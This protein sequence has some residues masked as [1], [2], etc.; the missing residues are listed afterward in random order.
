[1]PEPSLDHPAALLAYHDEL[2]F[3]A[4][5]PENA[6]AL[7]Q[8]RRE[9]KRVVAAARSIAEGAPARAR[10][11]L[12]GSGIAWSAIS[13]AFSYGIARWLAQSYP[14][15][16]EIDGAGMEARP[17]MEALRPA[18][19]RTEFALLDD[20]YDDLDAFF[21]AAKGNATQTNLA[22][23]VAQFERMPCGEQLRDRL[24]EALDLT[25]CV[26]PGGA[27]ISR[28][29]ARGLDAPAY[30]H[31]GVFIRRPDDVGRI[32][33]ER[34]PRPRA[35]SAAER[36]QLWDAARGV[37]AMLGRE[38]DPITLGYE[39]GVEYVELGRGVSIALFDMRAERRFALDTHL[40][41][42]LFKNAIPIG[43]G[44]GWPFLGTSKIG[45]NIFA[46]FRG[47]ESAL[48]FLQVLRVYH[49]RFGVERFLVEPYQF[50]ADNKEGLLSGAFWFYYRLGF[51]PVDR[52]VATLAEAEYER[53]AA[54]GG[55]RTSLGMMRRLVK[56]DIELNLGGKT[57]EARWPDPFDLSAAVTAWIA[58]EFA[59]DRAAADGA[60]VQRTQRALGV[61]G[62]GRWPEAE[63]RAFADLSMVVAQIPAL[64]RWPAAD[65]RA[66]IEVMRARGGRDERHYF[67][68]LQRHRRLREALAGIVA[69]HQNG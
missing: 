48:L 58:R 15:R 35:T 52:R 65:R 37:L 22:W 63:R 50:G 11:K 41:F 67:A 30:Y 20:E 23:L 33:R 39:D 21:T 18:M 6:A 10:A 45:V 2:L 28:T 36:R 24:Y 14:G 42:M 61:R 25:V 32:V 12:R 27:P 66:C 43:Y 40:G 4:A 17:V 49:Q 53:V 29:L 44:G 31:R 51:R 38:T 3:R 60:A 16:A 46:P 55:Y 9:L 54:G 19:P 68:L 57:A 8:T 59:G 26:E 34:V 56:S 69:N 1:V 47:G 7:A 64:E 5:Y 62:M 13:Y